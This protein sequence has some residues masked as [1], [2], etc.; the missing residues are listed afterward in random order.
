MPDRL[1]LRVD[2]ELCIGSAVCVTLAPGTFE[3]DEDDLV[4]ISDPTAAT[5]AE[6]RLAAD[7]CPTGAIYVDE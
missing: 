6:I 1:S 4:V 3:L 5:E 7:R 2:Q